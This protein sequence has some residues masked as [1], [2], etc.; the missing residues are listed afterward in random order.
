VFLTDIVADAERQ[1][2]LLLGMGDE[3]C[4]RLMEAVDW[5]NHRHGRHTVRS[6]G[7]GHSRGG[8]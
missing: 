4:M 3:R 5:I 8:G 2:S 7:V 6:L 1:P